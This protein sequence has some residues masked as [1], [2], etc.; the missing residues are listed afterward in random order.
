MPERREGVLAQRRVLVPPSRV[1]VHHPL[2]GLLSREGAEVVVF[3]TIAAAPPPDE[4]ALHAAAAALATFDWVV[5][6][7]RLAADGLL[8]AL[9]GGWPVPGPRAV[10]V[11]SGAARA[12]R[13]AGLEVVRPERHTAGEVA[14][15]LGPVADHRVLLVRGADASGE[16]PARL[17][18]AGAE[19]EDIAGFT[20]RV[21][22]TLEEWRVALSPAPAAVALAN[23]TAV[24]ILARAAEELRLDLARHLDGAVVAAAGPVTARAAAEAGIPAALVANG[25]LTGLVKALADRLLGEPEGTTAGGPDEA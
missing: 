13:G 7:G 4:G 3:P 12:L 15:A 22:A 14:A 11:G 16:L 20:V 6:A 24:R 23:P 9:A 5:V 25:H 17:C 21:V 10:A 8:A 19:V 1:A 2:A 18:S